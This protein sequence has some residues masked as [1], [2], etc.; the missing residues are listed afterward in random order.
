[1]DPI[2][3][4]TKFGSITIE[5]KSFNRDVIIR[6]NGDINKRKKKLSKAVYGTSHI[7]S[8]DEAEYV[9]EKGA[10]LLIVGS[11]QYDTLKL[12][13]EAKHY[14]SKKKC[15]VIIHDT[16]KAIQIWNKSPKNTI[17]LFHLTC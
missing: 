6:M 4:G 17:A 16:P 11:G 15:T 10:E 8:V 5:G 12:S 3:D 2:I 9:Y 7:M 1:M 14:L 13:D